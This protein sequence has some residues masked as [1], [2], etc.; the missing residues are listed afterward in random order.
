MEALVARSVFLSDNGKDCFKTYCIINLK[1][2][3]IFSEYL[4]IIIKLS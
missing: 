3:V 4:N 1:L 2:L